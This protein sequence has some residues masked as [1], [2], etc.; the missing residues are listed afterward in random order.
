MVTRGSPRLATVATFVVVFVG[1][2]SCDVITMTSRE[3]KKQNKQE[4]EKAEQWDVK[5]MRCVDSDSSRHR[6]FC[7]F[8]SPQAVCRSIDIFLSALKIARVAV[9][10]SRSKSC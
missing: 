9:F 7:D 10:L 6:F 1:R 8:V 4:E 3:N 2:L 5:Q